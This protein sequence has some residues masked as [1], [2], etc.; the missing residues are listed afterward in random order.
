M[1]WNSVCYYW[2]AFDGLWNLHHLKINNFLKYFKNKSKISL[3]TSN[4]NLLHIS[5]CLH[6]G[7]LFY[8]NIFLE[9]FNDLYFMIIFDK[10][11]EELRER[12]RLFSFLKN[13]VITR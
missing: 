13:I 8:S 10:S 3:N 2:V 7:T 5:I 6:I 9:K 4:Q 1:S 11:A 12:I